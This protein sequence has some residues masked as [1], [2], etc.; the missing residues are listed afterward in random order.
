M[1][2]VVF[3]TTAWS[4]VELVIISRY[5]PDTSK[6]S[7][8]LIWGYCQDPMCHTPHLPCSRGSS[9]HSW[10]MEWILPEQGLNCCPAWLWTQAA[11][12]SNLLCHGRVCACVCVYVRFFFFPYICS[13]ICILQDLKYSIGVWLCMCL[14]VF[15]YLRSAF[16]YIHYDS[17]K[18]MQN[19][20]RSHNSSVKVSL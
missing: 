3:F 17:F 6:C 8:S 7:S 4:Y 2:K 14:W 1:Y 10:W 15:V 12:Y 9:N 5:P 20:K 19:L 18:A 13:C 16:N 11:Q